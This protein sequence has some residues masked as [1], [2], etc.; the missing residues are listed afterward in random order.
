MAYCQGDAL[1]AV[2]GRQSCTAGATLRDVCYDAREDSQCE[3]WN[4]LKAG[5]A[6]QSS[7]RPVVEQQQQKGHWCRCRLGHQ[8][9]DEEKD[10][11]DVQ[12]PVFSSCK[13][14]IEN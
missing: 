9:Q 11:G 8:G 2:F 6:A 3:K 1:R 5:F 12:L 7:Q 4:L 10:G 14:D 13:A